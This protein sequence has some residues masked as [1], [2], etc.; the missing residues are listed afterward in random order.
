MMNPGGVAAK[1]WWLK[2]EHRELRVA[3]SAEQASITPK[4]GKKIR[5]YAFQLSQMVTVNLNA[6]RR[7]SLSFGLG[8]VSDAS[9]VLATFRQN[10]AD[11]V[12]N[13]T[14]SGLN[15]IGEVDE[16]VTLTNITFSGGTVV[17]RGIVYYNEE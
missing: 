7:A 10:K 15:V 8:K 5:V 12:A 1:K 9:K 17:T 14:L 13:I 6:S 16:T 11:D 4:S 2:T 3:A